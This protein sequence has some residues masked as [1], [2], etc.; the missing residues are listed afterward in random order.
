MQLRGA[1]PPDRN[2]PHCLGSTCS[3]P[4][5]GSVFHAV[6]KGGEIVA[7]EKLPH[8]NQFRSTKDPGWGPYFD[9]VLDWV[10]KFYYDVVQRLNKEIEVTEEIVD[11]STPLDHGVL[12][13]TSLL[14]DDHPAYMLDCGTPADNTLIRANGTGGRIMQTTGV[15]VD[16][17]D[18]MTTPAGRI[19][20]TTRTTAATY[21]VL[22]TD[23]VI[24]CD[25]DGNAI[26]ADLPAGVE[27]THYKLINCGSSGNSLTV[28]PNGSEKIYGSA[29]SLVVTD[30]DVVD[31]HYN[32]TEGW[33]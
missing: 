13:A 8:T 31:I 27:G 32:A 14:D 4:R 17:N 33:W 6:S 10:E 18:S 19:A 7:L 5:H 21:T 23:H 26:E 2:L 11:G 16:D 3:H 9:D 29:T 25:T 1:S 24:F 15:V 30:G 12:D 20:N 28:D 22:S